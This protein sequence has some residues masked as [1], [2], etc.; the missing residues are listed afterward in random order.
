MP[1]IQPNNP[2]QPD[3]PAQPYQLR[4]HVRI[5]TA[6]S[7]YDGHD[8]AINIMRRLLQA[9]GAEVIHL[10][11]NRSVREIV[12]C[13]IQEDAQ[14]VAITSYQ[15]GHVEFFKYMLDLL[16]ERGAATRIYGGGGGTILPDEIARLH[17]HGIARIF[18]PEDGQ[19]MGLAAMVNSMIAEC[20]V[21][22]AASEVDLDELLGGSV[23]AHHHR[24]GARELRLIEADLFEDSPG[25]D[26]PRDAP[27]PSL[28]TVGS[29]PA[30][31]G[32]ERLLHGGETR[33]PMIRRQAALEQPGG[34]VWVAMQSF[35]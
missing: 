28:L 21:D 22:L 8:A 20:D 30:A 35:P 25:E 6:A 5:V 15:G 27:E 11:H 33:N 13:A 7:L 14:G 18:S 19:R 12:D 10:G 3:K 9:G 34:Q 32:H 1:R 24:T 2:V 4:H 23:R 26:G 16:R 17:A 29:W 31:G